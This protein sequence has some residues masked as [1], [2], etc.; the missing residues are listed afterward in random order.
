MRTKPETLTRRS[1]LLALD[2]AHAPALSAQVSVL[3]VVKET[4]RN[5]PL[6]SINGNLAV[7]RR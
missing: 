2:L 4:S 6:T 5:D 3:S 1:R 7:T